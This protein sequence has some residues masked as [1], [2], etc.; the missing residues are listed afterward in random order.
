MYLRHLYL[1]AAVA[2]FVT[3]A[4]AQPFSVLAQIGGQTSTIAP[5]GSI[6][7][8]AP[9]IGSAIS[10]RFTVSYRGAGTATINGV[11][12]SGPSDF[13]STRVSLPIQLESG[14]AFSTTLTYTPAS[15]QPAQAQF[16]VSYLEDRAT[17]PSSFTF[18]I[19]GTVPDL[20]FSYAFSN[21]N[22]QAVGQAVDETGGG[23]DNSCE[24]RSTVHGN[25]LM[26]ASERSLAGR[27]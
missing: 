10:V 2:F 9:S 13:T 23:A 24:Q 26:S 22:A 6:N 14:T 19:N 11:D 16:L 5:G 21:G 12:Q 3:G 20:V 8:T 17:S 4:A 15:G 25:L 7:L 18:T 1:A 27:C